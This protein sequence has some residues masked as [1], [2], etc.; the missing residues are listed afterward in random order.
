[1]K[2]WALRMLID[3]GNLENVS[4]QHLLQPLYLPLPQPIGANT[5]L[6]RGSRFPDQE[7]TMQVGRSPQALSGG[8]L[9][10]AVLLYPWPVRRI[11]IEVHAR[12]LG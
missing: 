4:S 8:D 7:P 11:R 1:M 6:Q 5:C 9:T 2:G 10:F 3:V 12:T